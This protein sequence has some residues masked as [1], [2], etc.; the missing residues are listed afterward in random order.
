M[1]H[2]PTAAKFSYLVDNHTNHTGTKEIGSRI[3][4]NKLI[5][6]PGMTF[7]GVV[8]ILS[9]NGGLAVAQKILHDIITRKSQSIT[10]DTS[11]PENYYYYKL[12]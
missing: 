11:K 3:W 1:S 2:S 4:N 5:D 7:D 6:I 8:T 12:I 10:R 9:G